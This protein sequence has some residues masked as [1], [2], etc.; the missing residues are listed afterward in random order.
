ML[1]RDV[2][3]RSDDPGT[4]LSQG[5]SSLRQCMFEPEERSRTLAD[6]AVRAARR[7]GTEV[8]DPT[9]WICYLDSCPVV[10]GGTLSYRDT[11][12][13]TTEYAASLAQPL[14]DALDMY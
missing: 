4:C 2:P 14:G 3:K 8:V 7:T 10:I 11:D 9:P 13:L 12:H 5:D 6:V 1:L